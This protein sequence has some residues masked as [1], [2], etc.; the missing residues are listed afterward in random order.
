MKTPD[1]RSANTERN[2]RWH[3]YPTVGGIESLVRFFS[4]SDCP[5]ASRSAMAEGAAAAAEDNTDVCAAEA[6]LVAV[7]RIII[8]I[9]IVAF[10]L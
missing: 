6:E 10:I 9:R 4:S 5:R 1:S 3:T 8:K 7:N 2:R